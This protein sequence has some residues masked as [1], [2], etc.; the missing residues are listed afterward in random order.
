MGRACI[1]GNQ[2]SAHAFMPDAE[3]PADI[4]PALFI[5]IANGGEQGAVNQIHDFS[6]RHSLF[7]LCFSESRLYLPDYTTRI[8]CRYNPL[9]TI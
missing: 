2:M 8:I 6:M 5:G 1:G 3:N 4:L 9:Y 7:L